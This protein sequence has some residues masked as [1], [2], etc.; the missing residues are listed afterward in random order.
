MPPETLAIDALIHDLGA[1][2]A[3][4]FAAHASSSTP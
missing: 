2:R 1:V 3:A 4:S